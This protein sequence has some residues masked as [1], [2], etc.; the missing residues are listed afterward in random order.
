ML[1]VGEVGEMMMDSFACVRAESR[2]QC[3]HTFQLWWGFYP[4]SAAATT[5]P[6]R[7]RPLV[8]G[9]RMTGSSEQGF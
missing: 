3:S 7:S 8:L 9:T 5:A 2:S 6:E 1:Q 4:A